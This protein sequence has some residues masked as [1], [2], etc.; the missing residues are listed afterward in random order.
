MIDAR[1]DAGVIFAGELTGFL[2]D[3]DEA[4]R[5]RARGY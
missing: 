1:A 2:V 3:G 4:R 5:E